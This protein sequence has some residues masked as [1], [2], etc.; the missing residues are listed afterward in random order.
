MSDWGGR[1]WTWSRGHRDL[2][3]APLSFRSAG[4]FCV[5]AAIT[6]TVALD[7][8]VLINF[9]IIDR[10][11]LLAALPGVEFVIPEQVA[12]EVNRPAQA[13]ILQ[14]GIQSGHVRMVGTETPAELS[15]MGRLRQRV[16]HGEAACVAL[17]ASRGFLIA[18]DERGPFLRMAEERLGR[19]RI[20][21]TPGLMVLAIRA[22]LITVEQ[23]DEMKVALARHRFRMPFGSFRERV[24]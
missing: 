8:S 13:Q 14:D 4:V 22:G 19:G 20:V 17:A 3:L 1:L 9:L 2:A 12:A 23:A 21:T 15:E 10:I 16:G 5:P 18:C 7:A 11:D 24:S 6:G